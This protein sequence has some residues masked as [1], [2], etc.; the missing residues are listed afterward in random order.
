[1]GNMMQYEEEACMC[2]EVSD[3]EMN[4]TRM[5]AIIEERT[6]RL[7]AMASELE[8]HLVGQQLKEDNEKINRTCLLDIIKNTNNNL[9]K[10]EDKLVKIAAVIR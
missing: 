9:V 2:K 7:V 3:E 4:I 5:S 10:L 6:M 1:M 8:E